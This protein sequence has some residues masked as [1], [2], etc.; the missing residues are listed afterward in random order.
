MDERNFKTAS[1]VDDLVPDRPGLY[2]IRIKDENLLPE[3]FNNYLLERKHN[4]IYIGIAFT[5]LKKRFLNQEL[6]AKGHGTFFRSIGA[7][8]GYRPVKGSL[9]DQSNKRNYK[10]SDNDEPEI[11]KWINTNLTV[12]WLEYNWDYW[13]Y[14]EN[15]IADYLPLLNLKK[16]PLALKE[17]KVL[18]DE[19]LR[20]G[21]DT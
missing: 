18:R 9:A 21:R 6:R 5:S 17:L 19:C 1:S 4:I 3:P 20:I 12:N 13:E 8:L 15:L 2:C 14:E 10:F 7:V 11:I 16:N